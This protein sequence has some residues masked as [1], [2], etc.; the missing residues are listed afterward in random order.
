MTSTFSA[1]HHRSYLPPTPRHAS[2]GWPK[3]ARA[4]RPDINS[5][6]ICNK[7]RYKDAGFG[8]AVKNHKDGRST[9]SFPK[10]GH[11][12]PSTEIKTIRS[13]CTIGAVIE[14]ESLEPADSVV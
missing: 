2:N 14:W 10:L 5:R 1:V 8:T 7:P 6:V 4:S 9:V 11:V 12:E 3:L 13:M